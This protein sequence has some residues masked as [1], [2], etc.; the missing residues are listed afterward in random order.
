MKNK[1]CKQKILFNNPFSIKQVTSTSDNHFG[2]TGVNITK[3]T[4]HNGKLDIT[5]NW[6]KVEEYDHEWIDWFRSEARTPEAR[7][8]LNALNKAGK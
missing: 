8:M 5:V 1:G 6:K 4:S 2:Y 7:E 3:P